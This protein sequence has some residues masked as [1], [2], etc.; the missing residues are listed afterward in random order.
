MNPKYSR[1]YI[2]IKP[3]LRSKVVKTYGSFV[4]SLVTIS[5]FSFFAIR[6]TLGTIVSLKKTIVEEKQILEKL[7][8]KSDSLTLA[9]KNLEDFDPSINSKIKRL[10]PISTSLSPLINDL[11]SLSNI[12]DASISGVQFQPVD[13]QGEE[14]EA[15]NYTLVGV[16]FNMNTRGNYLKQLEFLNALTRLPRLIQVKSA[17]FSESADGGLVMSIS[18]SAF[19][20]KKQ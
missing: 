2:Y 6:P 20:Y 5:I 18:A 7:N 13:L 9:K 17:I 8:K 16:D 14:D 4:F 10:L 19:Y 15:L 12:L 1:Y 3:L 11:H